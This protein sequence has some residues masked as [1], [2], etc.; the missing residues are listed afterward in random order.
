MS[1]PTTKPAW[2]PNDD[3]T[4]II[5]PTESKQNTG[6]I[7]A[8][9]P[10]FQFFN[11]FFNRVSKWIS[12]LETITDCVPVANGGT[13]AGEASTARTNLGLGTMATQASSAVSI[14]G[15]SI[16]GITDL[17]IADGGTGASSAAATL[18]NLGFSATASEINRTIVV[19]RIKNAELVYQTSDLVT[20]SFPLTEPGGGPWSNVTGIDI[21]KTT[22]N[23]GNVKIG[24]NVDEASKWYY[25]YI[26]N[27]FTIAQPTVS[28]FLLT[29]SG[30]GE[31]GYT[32]IGAVYNNSLQ[33]IEPFDQF[34]KKVEWKNPIHVVTDS[35]NPTTYAD[36]VCSSSVPS[37]ST[38]IS[39]LGNVY[40]YDNVN[41]DLQAYL[42]V[43]KK[44]N[45]PTSDTTQI[46]AAAYI[47]DGNLAWGSGRRDVITD[48]SQTIQ[49]K[50]LQV[51]GDSL[52]ANIWVT[53]YYVR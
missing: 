38:M 22:A 2:I 13:G 49:Y 26:S 16:T 25:L 43:I 17:A 18:V 8:E 9:K 53:G 24:V 23:G 47:N 36:V 20:V 39:L 32:L 1:K 50:T 11:W 19:E 37:I 29:Q 27:S 33:D 3:P 12:Y 10:P 30:A 6:W 28:Q 48:S 52:V 46:L 14:S 4:K 41:H 15:G 44:G 34:G 51:S 7:A 35:N 45:T 31:S 21:T 5:A 42:Y 40:N